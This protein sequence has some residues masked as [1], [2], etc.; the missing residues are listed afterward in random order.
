MEF[1]KENKIKQIVELAFRK[2]TRKGYFDIEKGNAP[3]P[4]VWN[5][6]MSTI[7]TTMVNYVNDCGYGCCFVFSAYLPLY[8]ARFRRYGAS[9][10]IW[11]RRIYYANRCGNL[12]AGT[13][14]G[15]WNLLCRDIGMDWCRRDSR[16]GILCKDI[17]LGEVEQIIVLFSDKT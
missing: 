14:W 11:Y 7:P 3:I 8:L 1:N 16:I 6:A 10:G 2:I 15:G 4:G 12:L 17:S 13:Y 9:Y 5:K